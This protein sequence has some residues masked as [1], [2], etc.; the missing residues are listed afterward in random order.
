LCYA[1]FR[2]GYSLE[3]L[4]LSD[5]C[6][7]AYWVLHEAFEGWEGEELDKHK[8]PADWPHLSRA[9]RSTVLQDIYLWEE[10]NLFPLAEEISRDIDREAFL[11]HQL[12]Q[13]LLWV[14]SI[15]GHPINLPDIETVANESGG[16]GLPVGT[17]I[18]QHKALRGKVEVQDLSSQLTLAKLG[19]LDDALVWDA[20]AASGGKC[21]N[22]LD[23]FGHVKVLASDIR[24][25]I[26]ENL[27][28]RTRRHKHRIWSGLIDASKTSA[29]LQF[30]KGS[31]TLTIEPGSIDL[32]LTD[33]PCSGSGTWNRNPEFKVG[34]Q[35]D[36]QPFHSLQ[37]AILNNT[38]P[39]VKPGGRLLYSTCSVYRHENEDVV[40]AF[41]SNTEATVVEQ[42]YIKGYAFESDSMFYAILKK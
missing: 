24:A 33:V 22:L 4:N 7:L 17:A 6:A 23:R 27:S 31:E 36:L 14:R 39:Y 29:D 16:I 32:V 13:P 2:L 10:S 20:C 1:W 41:L 15:T 35:E 37:S 25:N 5:Q 18:D 9:E 11:N 40:D 12:D 34:F 30:N 26:L 42:G 28:Q 19:S 8:L 38:W 21:L 3:G